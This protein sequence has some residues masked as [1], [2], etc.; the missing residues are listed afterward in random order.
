MHKDGNSGKF[1][2]AVSILDIR[3]W[4]RFGLVIQDK[5]LEHG[6]EVGRRVLRDRP[7]DEL[8]EMEKQTNVMRPFYLVESHI[9]V[10]PLP[11]F[12]V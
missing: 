5:E 2:G 10:T 9:H 8:K 1:D 7:G 6:H 11:V 4:Q 3:D 12:P